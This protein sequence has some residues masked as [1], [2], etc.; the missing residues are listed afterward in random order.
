MMYWVLGYSLKSHAEA[1]DGHD[2]P[3][4]IGNE[5][6][7]VVVGDI[8]AVQGIASVESTSLV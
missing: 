1:R 8:A 6:V 4:H 3:P 2:R 5:V 7:V